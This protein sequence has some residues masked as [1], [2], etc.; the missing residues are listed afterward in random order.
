[1]RLEL[2]TLQYIR[3]TV[4]GKNTGAAIE[5]GHAVIGADPKAAAAV[6]QHGVDHIIRQ[7]IRGAPYGEAARLPVETVEAI[8]SA[9]PEQ[10]AA[11]L[12]DTVDGITAEAVV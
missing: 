1:M 3:R 4:I 5:T 10:M 6:F 11:I 9:D 2:I 12:V 7:P 8:R